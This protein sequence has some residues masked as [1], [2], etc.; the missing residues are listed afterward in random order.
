M[1]VSAGCLDSSGRAC[2]LE[3]IM[4]ILRAYVG[5]DDLFLSLEPDEPVELTVETI[6]A[7]VEWPP[8]QNS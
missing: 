3:A 2:S 5:E 8:N 7:T 4:Q 1:A 6:T